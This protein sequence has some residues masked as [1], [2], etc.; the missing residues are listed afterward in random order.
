MLVVAAVIERDGRILIGQR[1]SSDPHP[2]KWEFPGGKVEPPET[3]EDALIRELS[4]ELA[5]E[6]TIGAEIARYDRSPIELIFYRVMQFQ[7][8]PRNLAFEQIVWEP[9]SKLP[10]YDFLDGDVEFVRFL[11]L[12]RR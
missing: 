4:E 7:G 3:L 8:E 5:I 2:L 11:T 10:A 1:R 9:P 12:R 6:A